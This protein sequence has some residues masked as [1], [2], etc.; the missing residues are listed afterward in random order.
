M[1]D[2]IGAAA[3]AV[4]KPVIMPDPFHGGVE[5]EWQDWLNNF[6]ACAKINGWDDQTKCLFLGVRMKGVAQ[7]VYFEMEEATRDEWSVLVTTLAS[8]FKNTKQEEICK[9]QFVIKRRSDTESLLEFGNSI[10]RLASKAY[11]TM[12]P[13]VRDELARDQFIRGMNNTRLSVELRK[14]IPKTLDDT[15]RIAIEWETIENDALQFSD[16]GATCRSHPNT[17]NVI[18]PKDTSQ[19][20]L[21]M[22]KELILMLKDRRESGRG[23]DQRDNSFRGRGRGRAQGDAKCWSCGQTGHLNRECTQKQCWKCGRQGH[24]QAEC[25]QGNEQGLR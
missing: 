19:E 22:M 12:D 9:S 3:S 8:R 18:S 2:D 17:T 15:I 13:N 6:E 14:N 5:D 10:R 16:G 11:P 25:R 21:E 4:R 7:K 1:S 20:I 23:Q 24:L